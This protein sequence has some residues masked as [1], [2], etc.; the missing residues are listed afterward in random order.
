MK[1]IITILKGTQNY[2]GQYG[3]FSMT[4]FHGTIRDCFPL[5]HPTFGTPSYKAGNAGADG[6][7]G[8]PDYGVP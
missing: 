8:I 7:S 6:L 1:D 3:L 4:V 5:L 2:K